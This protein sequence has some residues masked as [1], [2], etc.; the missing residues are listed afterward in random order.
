[1]TSSIIATTFAEGNGG[2]INLS[3]SKIRL[4]NA[5]I[6]SSTNGSG[7][8]GS[9]N[10]HADLIEIAGST[11][12]DRASIATTSFASGDVGNLILNTGKLRVI[13]GASLSSSSFA[14]GDAG[15]LSI[16]ASESIEVSGK[17]NN[18]IMSSNPQSIIRSAIQSAT[19]RARKALGLPKVPSGNGGN[20]VINTPVLNITQEGII[21]V[22]NQGTG[23]A[24]TL[25]INA[26]NL[27]LEKAG[28]ITAAKTSGEGGHIT[29]NTQNLQIETG[30][31]IT[32]TADGSVDGGKI[33]INTTNLTVKK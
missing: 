3:T 31:Q 15:N 18:S 22:E 33:A 32:T 21:S 30:S 14:S 29:L 7:N 28:S 25:T 8:G 27:N 20:L 23:N 4:N 17:T 16:N 12:T 1:M 5:G 6:S 24:G 10:V 13:D 2:N 9:L 26:D 19:P 11:A